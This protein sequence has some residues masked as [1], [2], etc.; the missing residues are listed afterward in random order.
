MR[1][2]LRLRCIAG[3]AAM[4]LPFVLGCQSTPGTTGDHLPVVPAGSRALPDSVNSADAPVAPRVQTSEHELTT[5]RDP[6]YRLSFQ[7][8]SSW[9]PLVP[10]GAMDGPDFVAKLG[11]PLGSQA[12]LA[13][14]TRLA[15]T[16]LVGVS[17]SWTVKPGMDAATCSRMAADALPMG[18]ELPPE[19]LRGIQYRHGMGGDSG[20]CHHKQALLDTASHG[21]LC[22]VFER[23]LET[24][25]PDI[26]SP[27][28]DLDL[29]ATQR[30]QLQRQLD[31]IMASVSLR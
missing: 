31:G 21:G 13:D 16:N 5:F 30:A 23:D 3:A 18:T 25:C 1:S 22:Y 14:G 20:M 29:T 15:A 26:K 8:P 10:G 9:R 19:S 27:E 7:Y 12:F 24:T 17:F 11:A 28:K 4:L 2:L 6:R